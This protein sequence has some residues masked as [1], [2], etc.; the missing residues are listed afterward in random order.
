[1]HPGL[2]FGIGLSVAVVGGIALWPNES[3]AAV[4]PPVV[5]SEP[6]FAPRPGAPGSEEVLARA[7]LALLPDAA[8]ERAVIGRE[9]GA[10]QCLSRSV[11]PSAITDGGGIRA[12]DL[13]PVAGAVLWRLLEHFAATLLPSRAMAELARADQQGRGALAFAFAG[14][15]AVAG[16]CYVRVHGEH[17]VV[18]WLRTADGRVLARWRDFVRDAAQPW[19]RDELGRPR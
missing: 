9:V 6:G 11:P 18:E 13:D 3:Q 14:G 4:R 19:L 7:L 17:F 5:R 15:D 1:M 12:A 10:A 16:P 2:A 8:R